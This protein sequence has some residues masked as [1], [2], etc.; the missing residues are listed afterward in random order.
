MPEVGAA[1][2]LVNIRQP[3]LKFIDKLVQ[4]I[5]PQYRLVCTQNFFTYLVQYIDRIFVARQVLQAILTFS[6]VW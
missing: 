3:E 5:L 6:R 4:F 1:Y 2:H